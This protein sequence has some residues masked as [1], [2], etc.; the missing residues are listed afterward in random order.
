M[1]IKT[2][3]AVIILGVISFTACKKGSKGNST[4]PTPIARTISKKE[5][6]NQTWVLKETFENGVKKTSN[7]TGKYEFNKYGNFRSDVSGTMQDIGTYKF[8]NKD[9]NEL[10]VTFNGLSTPF[11]WKLLILN[12]T[13]LNTEF[14]SG[15][16]KL[17]YNYTR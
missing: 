16:A 14:M 11:V 8:T 9:S 10:S 5:L 2:K 6:L 7:G 4:E 12:E 1:N 17:N 3:I 13:T 15:T